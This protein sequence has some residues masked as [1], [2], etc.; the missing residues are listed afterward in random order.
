VTP[1]EMRQLQDAHVAAETR[2]DIV[3]A[4]AG[5]LKDCYYQ[6]IPLGFRIQGREGVAAYDERSWKALP[7]GEVIIEG[8]AFGEDM[9]VHWGTFRGTLRGTLLG[10]GATERRLEF[11]VMSVLTFRDGRIRSETL[12]FDLVT[13]CDQA[14]VTVQDAR[15]TITPSQ[16]TAHVA[17]AKEAASDHHGRSIVAG[18]FNAPSDSDEIRLLTGR[19]P[20]HAPGWVFLD[21]WETAGDGSPGYTVT[22]SNPNSA[23]LLLPNLR[24]DYIFV[25]WPSGRPGGIGHPH[26]RAFDCRRCWPRGRRSWR[27]HLGAH[28]RTAQYSRPTVKPSRRGPSRRARD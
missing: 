9:A 12:M 10:A 21:A 26:P 5:Y 17:E 28:A 6:N 24:W 8:E 4:T 19:R 14:G 20:P 1:A 3:G 2:K 16:I 25:R 15:M 11:P 13:L 18:D 22:K 7:D 27:R 23:P